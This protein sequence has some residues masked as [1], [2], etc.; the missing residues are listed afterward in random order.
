MPVAALAMSE[1]IA[2]VV[3]SDVITM[4]DVN[5]RTT[6]IIGSSNLGDT[7]DTRK[8]LQRQVMNALIEEQIRLQ[9]AERLELKVSDS[10]VNNGLANLAKQNNLSF[11][12]FKKALEQRGIPVSSMRRQ[13]QSR[14]AWSKVVQR[15]LHPQ[16]NVSESDVDEYIK[17]LERNIGKTEYLAAE[18]FLPV[19]AGVSEAEVRQLAYR[20]AGQLQSGKASFFRVAQQFSKA[21]GAPRGGDMGWVQDGD[22]E[23]ALDNALQTLEAGK[24]SNPV[25]TT[26]GYHILTV[27]EK[28][29]ITQENIPS[30]EDATQKL[31]LDRLERIQRRYFMDLKA[32]AFIETRV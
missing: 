30:R 31:G 8:R 28:R 14:I 24:V 23:Q 27:R 17:R 29:Q 20:L 19:E 13:I 12:D 7:P 6:M 10:E 32:S 26:V 11:G 4:T 2:A 3:N 18:I 5:D 22:L 25:K 15:Q 1:K 16:V 9:E 21:A